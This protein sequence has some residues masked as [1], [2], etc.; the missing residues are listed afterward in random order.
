MMRRVLSLSLVLIVI[1]PHTRDVWGTSVAE[2][3]DQVNVDSYRDFL[4]N[5]LYAYDGA[6]RHYGYEHYLA[7]QTILERFEGFGLVADLEPFWYEFGLDHNVVGILPGAIRPGEIYILGAHYD[8]VA[9]SPGA[10]DNA[11]GVAGV[12]ETARVLSQHAFEA[13][14]I[15]IAF[16]REEQGLIG[17]AAYVARHAHED[18]CGMI[19]LDCIAYQ[20]AEFGDF[21]YAKVNLRY[22]TRT[23]LVDDLAA[24]MESYAGLW[25]EIGYG[26]HSDHVSFGERGFTAAWLRNSAAGNPYLHTAQDSIDTPGYIDYEYATQITSGVVGYLATRARFSPVWRSP[27]LDGSGKVDIEDLRLLA[28]HWGQENSSFDISPPPFGDGIVDV[29]DLEGLM[30]Y[31]DCEIPGS[32]PAAY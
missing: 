3:V 5:D 13:T 10:N 12:L 1:G 27:D 31:W 9:V 6:N 14:I 17:S 25:C 26:G 28:D 11:S 23:G 4:Q 19:N 15:F 7:R 24:A 16:D 2:L 32:G 30:Y 29:K 22:V 20:P 21:D 8:A 18:I